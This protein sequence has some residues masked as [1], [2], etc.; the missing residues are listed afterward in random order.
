MTMIRPTALLLFAVC[1]CSALAAEPAAAPPISGKLGTPIQL[2][3]GKELT[4][5]KFVSR[6][7]RNATTA[8]A[9]RMEDVWSVK[10]GVIHDVGKPTG[11]LRT[12]KEFPGSYVLTVEYRH[13]TKGNGGWILAR[14]GEDKVWGRCVEVQGASGQVG[15]IWNQG[16]LKM[17]TDPARTEQ[18]GKHVKKMT[19]SAEKPIGEWNTVVIVVDKATLSITVNGIL[20]NVATD[21]E[22]LKGNVGLQS[23]GAEMEFR[24]VELTPIE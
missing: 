21:C 9:V 2:F 19:D 15:D 20:Q 3:N 16:M 1:A 10:D 17:S 11:Y 24:K 18:N 14:T 8:P 23:E 4:G 13:I 6:A 22:D 12:E 5:W 7:P